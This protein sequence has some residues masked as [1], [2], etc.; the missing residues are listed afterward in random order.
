MKISCNYSIKNFSP[1]LIGTNF[2]LLHIKN[3]TVKFFDKFWVE[4]FGSFFLEFYTPD[5]NQKIIYQITPEGKESIDGNM[6]GF[7]IK[8]EKSPDKIE[9]NLS[10]SGKWENNKVIG[11]YAYGEKISKVIND[12]KT[13]EWWYKGGSNEV[14]AEIIVEKKI[15]DFIAIQNE[16]NRWIYLNLDDL[17]CQ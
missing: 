11:I 13:L 7:I 8:N 2:R 15:V 3:G 9:Y 14:P 16:M 17:D 4:G 5:L 12:F 1:N 10:I 6:Y